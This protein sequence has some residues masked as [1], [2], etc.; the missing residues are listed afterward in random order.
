MSCIREKE[1][2]FFHRGGGDFKMRVWNSDS[3]L[4]IKEGAVQY[5]DGFLE[6]S[7]KNIENIKSKKCN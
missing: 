6:V 3:G 1:T 7:C 4:Q 5:I 2:N